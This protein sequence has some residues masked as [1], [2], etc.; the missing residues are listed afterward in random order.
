MEAEKTLQ[1]ITEPKDASNWVAPFHILD[2]VQLKTR[3]KD[4]S[5]IIEMKGCCVVMLVLCNC[6]VMLVFAVSLLI[7]YH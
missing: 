3:H 1:Q 5:M 7:S 4:M 2:L 6:V